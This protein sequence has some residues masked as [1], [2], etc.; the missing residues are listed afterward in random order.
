MVDEAKTA[1]DS[2]E[3]TE[4]TVAE[5]MA[6]RRIFPN[7]T[8]AT[9]YLTAAAESYSDFADIPVVGP[10]LDE[11][12]NFDAEIYTD[13][14][15]VMVSK[16]RKQG[17]GVKAIIVAPIPRVDVLLESDA[18]RQWIDKILQKEMNHV[19]VR[20]LRDAED[21]TTM[22][23]Q[24]PTTVEGY[25]TSERGV[26]GIME[27]FDALYK[28]IDAALSKKLPVWD[29]AR[30]IKS[31][32]KKA[33]ESKGYASEFF[34]ALEDYKGQSLFEAAL[35]IG[36]NAAKRKGLDPTI[37]ERW[38]ATRDAKVYE[39]GEDE[40]EELDLDALTDA[41]VE[42][43]DESEATPVEATE[44]EAEAAAETEEA[45]A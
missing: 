20:H 8:E 17:K 14:M 37:F 16:L 29:K 25:I 1:N 10:G 32:L 33:L 28:A 27:T 9:A 31:E 39:A 24:M 15:A 41:L 34:P 18:G 35:D 36:I 30:F 5:N 2:N 42:E 22:I 40:D 21:V 6:A 26:G 13:Q 45:T 4:K 43:A 38:K 3:S 19:A 11:E 7:V 44:E 12:G 23:D